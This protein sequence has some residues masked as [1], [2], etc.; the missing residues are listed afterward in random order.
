[1]GRVINIHDVH[2]NRVKNGEGEE[3][4]EGGFRVCIV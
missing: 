2:G 4:L 1:M 3:K